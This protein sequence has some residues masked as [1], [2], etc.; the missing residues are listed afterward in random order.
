MPYNKP[1]REQQKKQTLTYD[2]LGT[3]IPPQALHAEKAVLGSMML[4]GGAIAKALEVIE[5]DS[6]YSNA[7]KIIFETIISMFDRRVNVDLLTLGEELNR[8]DKLEEVGGSIYLSGLTT[9]TPT[10]ANV[11]QYAYIVQEKYLKRMLI[12]AAGSILARSYD[13]TTDALDEIDEAERSIFNIAEKRFNRSYSSLKD[14]AHKTY[15]MIAKLVEHDNSG[16]TGVATGLLELDNMTGGFQK[17]DLIIIAARPSMGKTALGLSIARNVVIDHQKPVA[18][19]SLEMA[20]VQIVIR[21][22]SSEARINQQKIR[23][24]KLSQEDTRQIVQSLSK[25]SVAPMYIDDSPSITVSELHAKCRRLKAEHKIEMIVVDYLQL[26]HAPRAE[27]REREISI[28]SRSLKQLAKELDIP[29]VALAQLNRSV[30]TR[31]D[32]RPMLSDLRESGSIE[33]DA[34][35]VM[36]INR[37]EVHKIMNYE[38]GVPTEGTGEIIIGKQRN[39]PIGTVRVAYLK[40][41]TLFDNLA[42]NFEA[43]PM[44]DD[45]GG[46]EEDAPF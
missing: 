28:I 22:I 18:F 6:F 14:L 29:V 31:T 5:P 40:D 42:L 4:D 15:E 32:K 12:N 19:F 8:Q 24:G 34:D 2:T 13:E 20:A 39:G 44:N 37:P 3:R 9:E 46:Y 45:Y 10:A 35:V 7:N 17:S 23:T 43:P 30:D 11:E 26:I 25:L 1:F 38:D 21:L 36:F 41:Y 16:I 27:S 33:Q